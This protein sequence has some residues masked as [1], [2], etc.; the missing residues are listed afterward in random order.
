LIGIRDAQRGVAGILDVQQAESLSYT[1][2]NA[3]I[4]VAKAA[5]FPSVTLTGLVN[6]GRLQAN[7][8]LAKAQTAEAVARYR[9]TIQQT[10]REVADGLAEVEKRQES[11]LKQEELTRVLRETSATARRRPVAD[12]PVGT[13]RGWFRR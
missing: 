2:A 3:N 5:L 7:V 1:A 4:G 13:H 10:F 9:Q 12:L 11:R 8:D 6:A